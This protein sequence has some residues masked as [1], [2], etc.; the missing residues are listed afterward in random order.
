MEQKSQI[1]DNIESILKR[2]RAINNDA[3]LV[4]VSKT[5]STDDIEEA[6]KAG[7][8][9]FGE[10][11]IQETEEKQK[12]LNEKYKDLS[13]FMIG[14]LQ[15]NKVN[16][17][18]SIFNMIQSVDSLKLAEKINSA[19]LK[20][21]KVLQCLLEIK[22]S[23]EE[24]KFGI[25]PV[26]A[27]EVYNRIKEMQGIKPAG[28]MAMAPYSDNAEDSRIYFKR[29]R[30]VFDEIKKDAPADF[31]WLSMGMSHDF[32]IALQEGANMVRVG[33]SLFGKRNY[34]K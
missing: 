33:T 24:T 28:I 3:L 27:F 21:G 4:A 17:A 15:T 11:K 1:K 2:I 23:P 8:K 16:K 19:C 26:E 30:K 29:A 18:V 5:F 7:I 14:H 32:E 31:G 22:V 10:S 9:V 25:S 34:T 12:V 20:E 13:W 6:V